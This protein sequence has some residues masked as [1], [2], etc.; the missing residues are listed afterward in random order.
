MVTYKTFNYKIK[1]LSSINDNSYYL[2]DNINSKSRDIIF[3]K[4]Y[5]KYKTKLD[6][7]N[8]VKREIDKFLKKELLSINSTIKSLKR[9]KKENLIKM[10][11]IERKKK[12][13]DD[14]ALKSAINFIKSA[15]KNNSYFNNYILKL[16]I[17]KL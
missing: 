3:P 17:K 5:T 8:R 2:I 11:E 12:G 10:S 14:M 9:L 13:R 15:N 16:A 6:I 1:K 7:E 4:V